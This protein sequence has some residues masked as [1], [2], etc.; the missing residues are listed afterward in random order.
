MNEITLFNEIITFV[1]ENKLLTLT[2]AGASV[3]VVASAILTFLRRAKSSTQKV[4]TYFNDKK[5]LSP[6]ME[7]PAYS[8]RMAYVLSEMS[9]LAYYEFEGQG[10]LLND[11]VKNA[12]S[13][14]LA[15]ET[16]IRK[17]L[18]EFSTDLISQRKPGI[19][20]FEDILTNSGF[21]LLGTINVDETQG[22][23]CKKNVPDVPSYVVVAFR[24]T[25][26]KVSDWLTDARA[27]PTVVGDKK[28]HT[29]FLEAF[30]VKTD[31]EG[32]T[33]MDRM[34][35]FLELPEVQDENGK[36]LPLFITGHS[37]GGALALLATRLVAPN[38]NGAC[39]TFGGPR[40]ANYTYFERVKTP[41]YRIV[42]SSDVVPTVPPGAIMSPLCRILEIASSVTK[43]FFPTISSFLDKYEHYLDKLSGYRHF[44]DLRYLTDVA[45]G[46][47]HDVKLLSNPPAIDRVIWFW[48]H[49]G[50]T[51]VTVATGSLFFPLKC[52]SMTGYR[53]KLMH[54]ANTRNRT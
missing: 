36:R 4:G 16:D 29:G 5:L 26:K 18:E 23:V 34:Q 41:V 37:L 46:Q 52:H 33:A 21:K 13:M 22:F 8:D 42:N 31:S 2:G 49:V 20:V 48:K 7:R 28:V 38:V 51:A 47:F 19:D 14:N 11:A 40:I 15:Q 1:T 25:E 45:G 6:P 12:L 35:A 24:G 10:G 43:P 54:V 53:K 17:F 50:T 3:P 39:Y 44:G 27:V 32:K 9:D 30:T